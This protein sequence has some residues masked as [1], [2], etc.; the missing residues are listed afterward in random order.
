MPD[1]SSSLDLPFLLTHA[2]WVR[3]VVLVAS[4]GLCVGLIALV[5]RLLTHREVRATARSLAPLHGETVVRGVLRGD[6][7]RPVLATLDVSSG[8]TPSRISWAALA[9]IETPDGRVELDGDVLVLAGDRAYAA[10]RGI[11]GQTPDVVE[12][13]ARKEHPSLHRPRLRD[14]VVSTSHLVMLA[15]GTK[16]VASGKLITTA[17]GEEQTATLSPPRHVA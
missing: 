15:P 4:G 3:W 8:G 7:A 5:R 6:G 1:L 2:A 9:W 13:H 16:V 10:R 12:A 14:P 11:P 17:S